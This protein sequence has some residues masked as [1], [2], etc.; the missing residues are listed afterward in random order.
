MASLTLQIEHNTSITTLVGVGQITANE[1]AKAL[2]DFYA[3]TPTLLVLCDLSQ[4]DLKLLSNEDVI[5]IAKLSAT[6][7]HVRR[8][9]KT[10]IIAPK[11]LVFGISRMYEILAEANDH[12]VIIR[13]F[14][15]REEAL[16]WLQEKLM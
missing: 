14:R 15:S 12:A 13:T 3:G 6:K 4:A 10:A 5:G 16:N 8:G 9:G 1:L 11:D 2:D 7:S